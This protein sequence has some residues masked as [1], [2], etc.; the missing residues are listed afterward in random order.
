M[1][2][3]FDKLVVVLLACWASYSRLV[4]VR[5]Y[6]LQK[7]VFLSVVVAHVEGVA[8]GL[9]LEYTRASA[10]YIFIGR[11][12]SSLKVVYYTRSTFVSLNL[13]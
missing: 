4:L 2:T 1:S 10:G 12:T 8:T 6:L 7:R 9:G 11:R 13:T 5:A 3:A